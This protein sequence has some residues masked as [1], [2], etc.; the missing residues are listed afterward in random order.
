MLGF[1]VRNIDMKKNAE[2]IDIIQNAELVNEIEE[3]MSFIEE[4]ANTY[5]IYKANY[6]SPFGEVEL[7]HLFYNF[8]LAIK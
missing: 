4:K 1:I 3:G 7:Q 8:S 2:K 5:C 6:L